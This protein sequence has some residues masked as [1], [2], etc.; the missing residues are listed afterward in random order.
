MEKSK[1]ERD[2]TKGDRKGEG[3]IEWEWRSKE[4][5]DRTKGD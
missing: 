2:R 3:G 5:R 4:E 1:E